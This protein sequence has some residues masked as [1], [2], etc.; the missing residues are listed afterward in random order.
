MPGAW[1]G[2]ARP[3]CCRYRIDRGGIVRARAGDGTGRYP[4]GP[5]VPTT[6]G[7]DCAHASPS[8]KLQAGPATAMP[9]HLIGQ[10][11]RADPEPPGQGGGLDSL[12]DLPG[13][14]HGR[15]G[16]GQG[17]RRRRQR[18]GPPRG[19]RAG[20]LLLLKLGYSPLQGSESGSR[21]R[22]LLGGRE[23]GQQPVAHAAAVAGLSR[24]AAPVRQHL[25]RNF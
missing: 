9:A 22:A 16:A 15:I 12:P 11:L 18:H 24:P 23:H 25:R 10:C 20:P 1:S 14:Q 13:H 21:A 7:G 5:R 4:E 19:R 17:P 8:V 6:R 3:A 2:P